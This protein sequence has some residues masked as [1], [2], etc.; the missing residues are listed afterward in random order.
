MPSATK[1][2]TKIAVLRQQG[3][4]ISKRRLQMEQ[5]SLLNTGAC[6][7]LKSTLSKIT[8]AQQVTSAELEAGAFDNVDSPTQVAAL[9]NKRLT[10]LYSTITDAREALMKE[11]IAASGEIRACMAFETSIM[12]DIETERAKLAKLEAEGDGDE[13]DAG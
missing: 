4:E 11:R 1:A 9:I 10:E 7:A 6:G 8:G 13:P 5:N 2:E 3:V 12:K